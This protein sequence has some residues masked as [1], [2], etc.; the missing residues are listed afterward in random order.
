MA[1]M[2]VKEVKIASLEHVLLEQTAPAVSEKIKRDFG[3]A[4]QSEKSLARTSQPVPTLFAAQAG[5]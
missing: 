3:K 1:G 2:F 5:R 4:R